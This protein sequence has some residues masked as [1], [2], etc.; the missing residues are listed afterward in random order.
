MTSVCWRQASNAA[1]QREAELF[2]PIQ[3]RAVQ[4]HQDLVER[5]RQEAPLNAPDESTFYGGGAKG[6][7][8]Y[9]ALQDR[10]LQKA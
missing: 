6:Y 4:S 1:P 8:D 10:L 5:L 7:T 9:P 2:R 3:L